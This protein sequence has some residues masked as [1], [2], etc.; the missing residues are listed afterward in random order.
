MLLRAFLII[1]RSNTVEGDNWVLKSYEQSG[2]VTVLHPALLEMLEAHILYLF[3]C[4][5]SALVAELRAPVQKAFKES[6]WQSYTDLAEIQMPLTGLICDRNKVLDTNVRGE[7]LIH[8]IGNI[9]ES[10][11]TLTTRLLLKYGSL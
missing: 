4:F 7:G 3:A 8:R 6:T 1:K 5:N 11:A 2:I 10:E 9:D